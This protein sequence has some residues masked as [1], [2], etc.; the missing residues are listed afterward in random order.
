MGTGLGGACAQ[1]STGRLG[2]AKD[3]RDEWLLFRTEKA[4]TNTAGLLQTEEMNTGGAPLQ[5][6]APHASTP[7]GNGLGSSWTGSEQQESTS[8][9][10]FGKQQQSLKH[11]SAVSQPH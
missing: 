10:T 1:D 7:S 5:P 8:S 3:M 11:F 9:G 4:W 2:F 6:A